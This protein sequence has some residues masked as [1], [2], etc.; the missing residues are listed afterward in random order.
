M[1]VYGIDVE[2]KNVPVLHK[3]FVPM[4]AFN[5]AFLKTADKDI[6]IAVERNDSLVYVYRTKIH[7]TEAMAD[8]DNFYVERMVK[9]LLWAVGGFRVTIYG[10]DKVAEFIKSTYCKG[11][12]R[13]FDAEKM[14]MVFEHEFEVLSGALEDAPQTKEAPKSIGGHIEGCRIGFDAGGSDRKV[15][16]VIDGEVVYSE[17]VVWNPKITSDPMYH[18]DGIVTALKTAASKMP[19]VD[20]VGISSAG[21]YINNKT[22][23]ASLFVAVSPEDFDKHV[24]NIYENAVK[25]LGADIPFEVANDGD[26]T[27]I[28]GA[29]ELNDNCVL[30]IAM[31]T[32]EAVG[33]V[34]GE[35][36]IKGWLNELAFAPVDAQYDT[37]V[38]P[39]SG[40]NGVGATYFSQDAVARLAPAAGITLATDLTPAQKLKEVQKLSE[41]EAENALQIFES[42]GCYL[43][44]TLAYYSTIYDIKNLLLLG[45]VMSGKGGDMIV[46][47]CRQVLDTEYP[48]L[49]INIALPDEKNRRVGQSVAAASLPQ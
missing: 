42:I 45:R 26:V 34:D 49:S 5:K 2:I 43:G 48:E 33:Y 30:G 24:K 39:W 38:D 7:G 11:G 36:H 4:G 23:L 22:R 3:D 37:S 25:E 44:H 46:K 9:F 16:A 13:E 32:S 18:F 20:A 14:G 47:C 40:D 21:I 12:K 10:S 27:A 35:G 1:K 17:E 6:A 15:S 41:A 8:A 29:V 19:R 31:G 28:A